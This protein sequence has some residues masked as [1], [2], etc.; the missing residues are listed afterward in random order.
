MKKVHSA[1]GIIFNDQ[2]QV[3]ICRPTNH[4]F[5][6]FPKGEV[7]SGE[8][9]IQ[10][11]LREVKEEAGVV[12]E[13]IDLANS[14][15]FEWTHPRTG[16]PEFKTVTY[17]CMKYLSGDISV[18]DWEMEEVIWLDLDQAQQQLSFNKDKESLQIA[19]SVFFS[20]LNQKRGGL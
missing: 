16:K 12:A 14:F 11:A 7:S 8:D 10:A 5:W 13:I 3:I 9:L 19:T 17:F 15:S 2:Q 1:G 18:H 20:K 6:L 4:Q